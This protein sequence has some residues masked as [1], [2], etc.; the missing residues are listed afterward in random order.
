M[1]TP[2][3]I[4]SLTKSELRDFARDMWMKAQAAH[5]ETRIERNGRILAESRLAVLE[6]Q[7]RPLTDAN[8]A[9]EQPL[10]TTTTE[11]E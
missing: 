8:G 5:T 3:V 11:I 10:S 6:A 1:E 2:K 7:K 9:D 4:D